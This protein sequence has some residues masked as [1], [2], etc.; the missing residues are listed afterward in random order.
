MT[1]WKKNLEINWILH[2]LGLDSAISKRKLQI[3]K[4][5][6][7]EISHIKEVEGKQLSTVVVSPG[8]EG[9]QFLQFFC[10][11]IRG[12]W[13]NVQVP[14]CRQELLQ[15]NPTSTS[16]VVGGEGKWIKGPSFQQ[17]SKVF[18]NQLLTFHTLIGTNSLMAKLS[19]I[20]SWS[21]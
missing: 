14:R 15:G 20:K 18:F 2:Q 6:R 9:P 19:C 12:A 16:Q 8:Y 11:T 7:T 21:V 10:S 3:R 1:M 4:L 13:I 17:F 5:K